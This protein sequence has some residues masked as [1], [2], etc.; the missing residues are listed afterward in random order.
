MQAPRSSRQ[1]IRIQCLRDCLLP[2]DSEPQPEDLV[3]SSSRVTHETR[4]HPV[5][6]RRQ[7]GPHVEILRHVG[8][9]VPGRVLFEALGE[10]P[11]P[12]EQ[13]T[14]NRQLKY[15]AERR[16]F[17]IDGRGFHPLFPTRQLAVAHTV[18][19]DGVRGPAL[20]IVLRTS[21]HDRPITMEL[22]FPEVRARHHID[23]WCTDLTG[24]KI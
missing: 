14:A 20:E 24:N 1:H 23:Q 18:S 4:G 16:R 15:A 13:S 8:K 17:T 7:M 22:V 19:R 21:R 6:V 12:R 5:T 9:T 2:L 3:P 10:Q 11:H